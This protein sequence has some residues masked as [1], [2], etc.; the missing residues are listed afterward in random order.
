MP[1]Q[2]YWENPHLKRKE[3]K[4]FRYIYDVNKYRFHTNVHSEPKM[5]M[6]FNYFTGD[7]ALVNI[8]V[9]NDWSQY[10]HLSSF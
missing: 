10:V 2:H 9:K 5:E 6:I 8:V 3:S 4:L 1:I 7:E